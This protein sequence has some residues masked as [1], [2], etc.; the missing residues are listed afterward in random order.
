MQIRFQ[1][2]PTE[3]QLQYFIE[4]IEHYLSAHKLKINVKLRNTGL[5]MTS[6]VNGVETEKTFLWIEQVL[7]ITPDGKGYEVSLHS[8][9]I[10]SDIQDRDIWLE[11]WQIQNDLYRQLD[12][13]PLPNDD[14][15]PYWQL[16]E[17][18]KQ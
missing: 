12:L 18:N 4:K 9:G 10:D 15:D 14:A 8:F 17:K 5:L 11:A 16:W 1:E 2:K 6:T 13:A 7:A 3:S